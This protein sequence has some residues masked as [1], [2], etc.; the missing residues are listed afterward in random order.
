VSG[1]VTD[2]RGSA[3]LVSRKQSALGVGAT[4]LAALGWGFAGVLASLTAAPGLVLTF[5][6]SWIAVVVLVVI[7]LSFGRRITWELLRLSLLGGL[8]LCAD[9]TLFFS[10]VKLTSVAVVTVIGALQP[11]LLL[12]VAG[13]MLD[14][15]IERW[16]VF[17]TLIAI[18]GVAVIVV[19]GGIPSH[20]QVKGDVFAVGSLV[21]WAGYFVASKR[22]R[23]HVAALE[24]TTGVTIVCAL[25]SSVVVFASRQP[26]GSVRSSDWVWIILLAVVPSSGHV[27]VNWA[28]R[29]LDVTISSVIVSANPVVAAVGAYFILGQSLD[30][31]QIIGGVVGVAAIAVVAGRRREPSGPLIE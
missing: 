26:V 29:F 10:A 7:V 4:A 12:I 17:W 25:A 1:T 9:M 5:Y 3:G 6:R 2:Q 31:L 14:E 24:Y 28:H 18:A 15:R 27:L 20:S 22:A 16:T 11:A 13:P 30:P 21:G 8:F 23:P 19:G